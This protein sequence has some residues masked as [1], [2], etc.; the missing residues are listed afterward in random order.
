[1]HNAKRE[2]RQPRAPRRR[3][4]VHSRDI[5]GQHAAG[6]A[7][8]RVDYA[9]AGLRRAAATL[10]LALSDRIEDKLP[11]VKVPTLVVRGSRDV[12]APQAWAEHLTRLLPCGRLAIVE[13]GSHVLSYGAPEP[14]APAVLPFLREGAAG[15]PYGIRSIDFNQ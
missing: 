6:A 14:L 11:L 1:M 13:S 4:C 3:D 7:I 12:I 8:S 5:K 15:N 9:K 2:V 10:R